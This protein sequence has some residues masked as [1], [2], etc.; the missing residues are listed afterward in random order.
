MLENPE[1]EDR[2]VAE[3]ND[4]DVQDEGF[5]EDIHVPVLYEDDPCR[6]LECACILNIV[7]E[8]SVCLYFTVILLLL[9]FGYFTLNLTVPTFK[10][11]LSLNSYL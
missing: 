9:R 3:V 10:T 1:E 5:E 7:F 11:L 6:T 2:L 4:E 8:V